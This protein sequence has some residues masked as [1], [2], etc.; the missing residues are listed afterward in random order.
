MTTSG[1]VFLVAV[2]VAFGVFALTLAY[3]SRG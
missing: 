2:L 1:I 3:Y